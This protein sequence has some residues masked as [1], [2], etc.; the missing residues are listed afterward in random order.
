MTKIEVDSDTGVVRVDSV[1]VC[2]YVK[3]G[4]YKVLQ[5]QD[6][7]GCKRTKRRGTDQVEVLLSEF[8]KYLTD[9]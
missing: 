7:P 5:F 1:P 2:R 8:I 9:N 3:R 6:K 4:K